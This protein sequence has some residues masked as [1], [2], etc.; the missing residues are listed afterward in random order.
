LL[1][2]IRT[3]HAEVK[4]AYG[5]PRMTEEIRSRGVPASKA[6]AERVMR[7][8]HIR[9]R[10]KRRYRVTTDSKHKLPVAACGA[11]PARLACQTHL[12]RPPIRRGQIPDMVSIH[13]RPPE[14]ED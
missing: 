4:G 11:L 10:H 12:Y 6:R 13:V 8:N 7:E 2:L 3:I 14:I 9:A 1:A 5:S